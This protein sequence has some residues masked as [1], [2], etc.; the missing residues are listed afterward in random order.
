M[1]GAEDNRPLPRCAQLAH[2]FESLLIDYNLV[3]N[4]GEDLLHYLRHILERL[5]RVVTSNRA[6]VFNCALFYLPVHLVF[7]HVQV[8]L[9]A[10]MLQLLLD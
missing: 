6:D 4:C 9:A 3:I 10:V 1:R 5:M 8:Q 7:S 2:S